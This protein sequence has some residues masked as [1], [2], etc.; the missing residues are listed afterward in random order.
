VPNGNTTFAEVVINPKLID[1]KN[2]EIIGIPKF[3]L[4]IDRDGNS[5]VMQAKTRTEEIKEDH[6]MTVE[7][8]Q[9]LTVNR[10]RIIKV[11][12]KQDET[13]EGEHTVTGKSSSKET[14]SKDKVIE[15]RVLK[16]G[17]ESASEPAVLGDK[18]IQW[19]ASHT[20]PGTGAPPVQAATVKTLVSKKV[21]VK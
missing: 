4:R 9:E 19:L 3:A 18:L 21:R 12:G 14:W 8:D 16:L 5:Y 1:I 7:R 20:H 13:I 17:A 6:K 2:E 11:V 15:A 10:D